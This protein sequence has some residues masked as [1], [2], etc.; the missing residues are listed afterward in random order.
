KGSGLFSLLPKPR[1]DFLATPRQAP[2]ISPTS[3]KKA[4]S[5][6]PRQVAN[7][8]LTHNKPVRKKTANLVDND[9]D[10]DEANETGNGEMGNDFFTIPDKIESLQDDAAVNIEEYM[11]PVRKLHDDTQPDVCK[12]SLG[13]QGT[14]G[15]SVDNETD[16]DGANGCVMYPAYEPHSH[17]EEGD[18]EITDEVIR[19]LG[20]RKR[21]GEDMNSVVFREVDG[22]A[23]MPDSK[24]WLT[25]ALSQE[26]AYRPSHKKGDGPTSQQKRKHQ[27]TYLAFQ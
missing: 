22:K 2:T 7:K 8:H 17:I 27:I 5:L 21:K 16:H 3:S 6:V 26:T 13:E 1:H 25:K 14:S 4:N 15:S 23:L 11:K 10:S 9:D 24:E 19:K 18:V 20:G 12:P